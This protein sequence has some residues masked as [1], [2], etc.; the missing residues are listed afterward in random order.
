MNEK[1]PEKKELEYRKEC[2]IKNMNNQTKLHAL[3]QCYYRHC[4]HVYKALLIWKNAVIFHKQVLHRLKLRLIDEH[5][6]RLRISFMRWKE[7]TDKQTHQMLLKRT[8]DHMNEN[9]NLINELNHKKQI[10]QD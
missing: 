10:Q 4:D 1:I 2:L 7:S 6:R 8:E 9:Q 3:R 5:K